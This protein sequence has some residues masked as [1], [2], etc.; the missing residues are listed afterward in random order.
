MNAQQLFDEGEG[1]EMC[2]DKDEARRQYEMA[3]PLGHA[4]AEYKLGCF[5]DFG[6]GGLRVNKAEAARFYHLAAEKGNELAQF[7]L[8]RMYKDGCGVPQNDAQAVEW[9]RRA[10][11]NQYSPALWELGRFMEEGRGGLAQD[12]NKAKELY[13]CAAARGNGMAKDSLARLTQRSA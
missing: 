9:W 12:L 10:A 7:S 6:E 2:D 13:S 1:F 3:A 4:G 11:D 5:Y 8:G